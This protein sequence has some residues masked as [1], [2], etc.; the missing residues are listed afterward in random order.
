MEQTTPSFIRVDPTASRPGRR[1]MA[2]PHLGG[3]AGAVPV[4]GSRRVPPKPSVTSAL[5]RG[6]FGSATAA[7]PAEGTRKSGT[8]RD[9]NS[10]G[11]L[12]RGPARPQPPDQVLSDWQVPQSRSRTAGKANAGCQPRAHRTAES[13]CEPLE[14]DG[15]RTGDRLELRVLP[16]RSPSTTG[17]PP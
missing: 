7:L 14:G 16:A 1:P 13:L 4:D 11:M 6:P 17:A 5:S 8:C 12:C 15:A 10:E 3:F 2:T 9:S